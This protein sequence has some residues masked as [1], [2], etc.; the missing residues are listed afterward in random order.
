MP[1]S[2]AQPCILIVDDDSAICTVIAEALEREGYLVAAAGSIAEALH[3][4]VDGG[5][6]ELGEEAGVGAVRLPF[7]AGGQERLQPLPIRLL[8]SLRSR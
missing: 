5:V 8:M 6:H 4:P 1:N 3:A 2:R 7:E